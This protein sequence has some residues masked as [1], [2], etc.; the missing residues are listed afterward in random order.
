MNRNF[1]RIGLL[2]L[3]A[4]SLSSC[5][6]LREPSRGPRAETGPRPWN[7]VQPGEGAGSLA[8]LNAMSQR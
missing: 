6:L 8:P 1:L 7:E 2:A 5:G 4:A 3:T